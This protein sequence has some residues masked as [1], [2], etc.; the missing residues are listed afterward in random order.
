VRGVD[1]GA[2]YVEGRLSLDA[3]AAELGGDRADALAWLDERR[4][5]RPLRLLALSP[6]DMAERLA[7]I[8]ADRLRGPRPA[9]PSLVARSVVASMRLAGVDAR[10][11][12]PV[13]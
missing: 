7:R 1:L 8:R 10:P 3:L 9:D 6:A 2:E 4:L 11:W 12:V 13:R 5:G